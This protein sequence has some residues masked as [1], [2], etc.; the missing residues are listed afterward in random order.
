MSTLELYRES[1]P[2]GEAEL[3]QAFVEHDSAQHAKDYPPSVRPVRRRLH[4]KHHGCVHARFTVADDLPADLRVGIFALPRSFDAIVRFSNGQRRAQ[5]DSEPD[6][7]GMAIKLF[8]VPGRK[9]LEDEA[10]APTQDLTFLNAPTFF[11]RNARDFSDFSRTLDRYGNGLPFVLGLNPLRL[12]VRE[13]WTLYKSTR[14][15]SNPLAVQYW[16]QSPARLGDLAVKYTAVPAL[17]MPRVRPDQREADYLRAAMVAQLA[18]G[19]VEFE[20]CVQVQTDPDR[21]PIEDSLV[22]WDP[23]DAPFRSIA[24]LHIPAQT[25]A[26]AARDAYCEHLSFTAW[27]SLPEHQPLGGINRM[28]RAAYHAS[29]QLRHAMNAVPRREPDTIDE[30]LATA[31]PEPETAR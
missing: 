16:T 13:L 7:R 3:I 15:I 10:D 29:A 12:R 24:R 20:L 5:A 8:G 2:E 1:P 28:R 22:E 23:K 25:F 26:T 14:P 9:L 31:G 30:F 6:A 27:H 19:P 18:R 17:G 21:M 4:V 11:V